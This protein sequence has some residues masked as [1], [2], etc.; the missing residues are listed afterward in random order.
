MTNYIQNINGYDIGGVNFDGV[1][2]YTDPN[3]YVFFAAT[4]FTANKYVTYSLANILPDDNYTYLCLFDCYIRTGSTSGNNTSAI[5]FSGTNTDTTTGAWAQIAG[6]RTRSSSNRSAGGCCILPIFPNDRNVT[7]KNE[8]SSGTSGNCGFYCKM[9]RR[10][11][12][13][14]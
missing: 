10:V 8:T 1:W 9:Y 2:T 12:T 11:G 6:A 14:L 7:F 13:N 3:N 5:I 4:T